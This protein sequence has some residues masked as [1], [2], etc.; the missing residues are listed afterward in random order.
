MLEQI[1]NLIDIIIH[2]DTFLPLVIEEYGVYVYLFLFLIVFFETG[3]VVTPYLPGDSLLFLVGTI[4]AQG[5]LSILLSL[6]LLMLAAIAGDTLNY[7]IGRLFGTRV[8]SRGIPFVKQ[9]H[10]EKTELFF[11]KYGGKA[12]IIARFV[13]FVRTLAPFLAG[14][15]KMH[16]PRFLAFNVVGGVLWVLSFVLAG[17]FFGNIPIISENINIVIF[18]IIGVSLIG[19][20]SMI[21][22]VRKL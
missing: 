9:H 11:E 14:T 20:A 12:I 6:A 17:F 5:D 16:Y 2:F 1:G 13:P 7:S 15:G 3:V 18:V 8:L 4:A 19:V 10:I 22:D 21:F